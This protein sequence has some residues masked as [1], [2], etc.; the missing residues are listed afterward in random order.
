MECC[1]LLLRLLI[2]ELGTFVFLICNAYQTK[3]DVHVQH[4]SV[5]YL[6]TSYREFSDVTALIH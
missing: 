1:S 4:A 6:V 3:F 2:A 5:Y